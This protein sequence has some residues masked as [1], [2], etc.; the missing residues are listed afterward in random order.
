MP[1]LQL[2][3]WGSDS[4]KTADGQYMLSKYVGSYW[5]NNKDG[6]V[7]YSEW[8]LYLCQSDGAKKSWVEPTFAC[9]IQRLARQL[10]VKITVKRRRVGTDGA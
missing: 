8:V 3:P 2:L 7:R 9:A 5:K 1:S 6:T 4:Y 10:A